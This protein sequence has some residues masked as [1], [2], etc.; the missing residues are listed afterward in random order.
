[1]RSP[2]NPI[3]SV[4]SLVTFR[5]HRPLK[6][7]TPQPTIHNPLAILLQSQNPT[8]IGERWAGE[9]RTREASWAQRPPIAPQFHDCTGIATQLQSRVVHHTITGSQHKGSLRPIKGGTPLNHRPTQSQTPTAIQN[10]AA[11]SHDVQ[12]SLS[13]RSKCNPHL[14]RSGSNSSTGRPGNIEPEEHREAISEQH[15]SSLA[16]HT[17]TGLQHMYVTTIHNPLA[18]LLQS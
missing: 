15:H 4:L 3:L 13:C 9:Y 14:K 6:G 1:M 12:S 16:H 7:G 5:R 18:I 2:I 8:S 10:T 17:V 11:P